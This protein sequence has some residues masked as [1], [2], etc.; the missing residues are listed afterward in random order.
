M[1]NTLSG[2]GPENG[3]DV[4]PVFL[5][6]VLS[7]VRQ[8]TM[9][10]LGSKCLGAIARAWGTTVRRPEPRCA[11]TLIELLVVMAV[12]GT[13][14]ALL[15]PVL[16]RAI[17]V[18]RSTSCAN[19]LRQFYVVL[20]IHAAW[21][22]GKFPVEPTEHNPHPDLLR[23]L[24]DDG[25]IQA[26]YCPQAEYMEEYAQDTEH[27]P[28]VGGSDS[29]IDTPENRAAG[30]IGYVYWSF[31]ENKPGWR[32]S[33]VFTPRILTLDG[34]QAVEP[35]GPQPTGQ[36]EETWVAS[37]FFRQGAPFPHLRQHASGLNVVFLDG[38]GE[39]VIGRPKDN[40]R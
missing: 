14:A 23:R 16:Q 17:H 32:N 10:V 39:L 11:F 4:R 35:G 9:L 20:S 22:K 27:Y 18:A 38:H 37:D 36:I 3:L 8:I 24:E 33:A 7:K 29:V 5:D 15:M 12:M 28:P 2:F 30:N 25:L 26:L 1:S 31:R 19:N 21:N 40:F 6:R 13:L 34:A